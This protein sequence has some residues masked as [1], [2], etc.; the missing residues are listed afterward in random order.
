MSPYQPDS[1]LMIGTRGESKKP[2]QFR[3]SQNFIGP[4]GG[5]IEDA[6]FIPPAAELIADAMED[7]VAP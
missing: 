1:V 7:L 3:D 2:G 6:R 4:S 5:T